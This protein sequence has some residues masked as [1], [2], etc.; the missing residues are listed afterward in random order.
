MMSPQEP[1]AGALLEPCRYVAWHMPQKNIGGRHSPL[2]LTHLIGG[3][4]GEGA[5]ESCRLNEAGKIEKLATL[6]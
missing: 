3:A 4:G 1:L 2:Q 6:M 5:R